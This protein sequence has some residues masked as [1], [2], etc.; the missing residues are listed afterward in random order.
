MVFHSDRGGNYIS[1]TYREYLESLNVT[2]SFSRSGFPYDNAVIESFF[3][4]MKRK[5]LYR[6]KYRS[7]KEF[8][9]AVDTYMQFYNNKRPH[10]NN[11]YKAPAEWETEYYRKH[12]VLSE[13]MG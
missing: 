6:T 1:Y 4:N 10:K 11:Q 7:E 9:A 12:A 2:Q 5:E 3:S 8:K 13:N